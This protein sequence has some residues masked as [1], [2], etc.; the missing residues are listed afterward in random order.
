MSPCF[1]RHL[2]AWCWPRSTLWS[3]EVKNRAA[4]SHH[5]PIQSYDSSFCDVSL[6]PKQAR[7]LFA[8]HGFTRTLAFSEDLALQSRTNAPM[9]TAPLGFAKSKIH[10]PRCRQSCVACRNSKV[11]CTGEVP[12]PRC[13]RLG[14]AGMCV[15]YERPGGK[16]TKK[17]S[18][19]SVKKCPYFS[20][21]MRRIAVRYVERDEPIP[22]YL[23]MY[24]KWL[25]MVALRSKSLKAMHAATM[26]AND[27]G[28]DMFYLSVIYNASYLF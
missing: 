23:T 8:R 25:I 7:P 15:L 11:K 12:C 10:K 19:L 9:E 18:R 21:V 6:N 27:L 13:V 5:L 24:C 3:C 28:M 16:K 22:R 4:P 17:P 20:H 26:L 2:A 1:S 14:Q